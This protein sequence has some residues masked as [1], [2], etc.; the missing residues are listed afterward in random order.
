MPPK[1]VTCSVCSAEV[2]KAQTLARADGTRACRSHEG[3][4][5]EAEKRAA[6]LSFFTLVGAASTNTSRSPVL[7]GRPRTARA[8]APT[9]M[10]LT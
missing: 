1:S 2:L 8:C 9:T 10:N 5:D 3:V 7:L 6:A 4:A